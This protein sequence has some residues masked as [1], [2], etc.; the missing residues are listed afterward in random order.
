MKFENISKLAV[1][2]AGMMG[3]QIAEL[4]A[5]T[6]YEVVLVDI[7]DELVGKGLQSIDNRLEKFFV[8][9]GKLTAEQKQ[10]I[11]GRIKG[12]SSIEESA[13]NADFVIEAATENVAIKKDI[14]GKLDKNAPSSTIIASNTSFQNISQCSYST[15]P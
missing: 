3:A 6:G 9:K 10:E 4:L 12:N 13:K 15:T 2:G 11:I 14:L 7:S 5:R 1:I 8:A